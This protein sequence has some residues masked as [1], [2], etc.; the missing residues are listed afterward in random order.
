MSFKILADAFSVARD[1]EHFIQLK[2]LKKPRIDDQVWL[3]FEIVGSTKFARATAQSII[4]IVE[5]TYFDKLEL[6][7]YER[8]ENTLK[9]INLIYKSFKEKR[10]PKS[11]GTI[12]A[13]I[14]VMSG[15]ELHLTQSSDAEAY[16]IRG[17]KLSMISEGL[18]GKSDD[19]FVNIASG[20]VFPEDKV[21]FSTSRLL[22][23]ATQS[24]LAQICG[25]GVTEALDSMR[26]L[27]LADNE[28]SIGVMLVHAK[29][30]HRAVAAATAQIEKKPNMMLE[31]G[32]A[33]IA[34]AFKFLTEKTALKKLK[35][36]K[37]D[38]GRNTILAAILGAALLL[39]LSISFLVDSQRNSALR[40]EYRL[41][42]EA[43]NQDLHT[44]NTKGY[45]NDKETANA[46]LTKV[47]K[48][49]Q[50]ILATEYFRSEALALLDKVEATRDSINNVKR[51][52]DA[53]PYADLSAKR[54]TVEALGLLNLNDNFFAYEYNALYEVILDQ[55]LDPKTIDTTEVVV[56]GTSME[57][58]SVLAFLTQSGRVIEYA[59]DQFKFA[60]TE[61][62][63]FKPA[64]DL[65]A[66][67]KN[68]YLLS[69]V[70][71]QIYKY[72]RLR[73]KY[74]AATEYNTDADLKG[75][76][77][78]AIDGNIYILKQGGEIV[79]IFKSKA[80]PFEIEDLPTDMITSATQVFTSP[81]LAK[82]YIL[83][84][85]NNRVVIIEKDVGTGGRYRGQIYFE[86]LD[87][88]QS[89]YVDKNESKLY[90]LTKKYIYQV[91]I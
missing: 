74:S 58:Q 59:E 7:S 25:D 37:P 53:K 22:R 16:L 83:D 89:I 3:A 8:F 79:K 45:A 29:A 24:Q 78:F 73:D 23:L 28:L 43:M 50:D 15:N 82:M 5:D 35:I 85:V 36:K 30:P 69:P 2:T 20:E 49:A 6:E 90:L 75:A 47:E 19:L 77:S 87:K 10:G 12:S 38:W 60:S 61:D 84:P 34:S 14:A 1:S 48:E 11:M 57:D 64:V 54:D 70:N 31:K 27:V 81:E 39:I 42:I 32:K 63:G 65:K 18:S 52:S 91:E 72:S 4:E 40:E 46:I 55:V 44:A 88:I 56:A 21:I 68:L 62:D 66:Y 33:L 9:E 86:N 17:N 76:I 80:Q 51:I 41:R 26:E 13:I 67:G 71:N